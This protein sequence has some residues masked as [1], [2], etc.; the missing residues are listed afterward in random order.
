[1]SRKIMAIRID[2]GPGRASIR[3]LSKSLRGTTYTLQ[4]FRLKGMVS[5]RETLKD[6]LAEAVVKV[7]PRQEAT[8]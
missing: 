3:T 5:S 6:G 7:L 1:M 2:H 4:G 8:G